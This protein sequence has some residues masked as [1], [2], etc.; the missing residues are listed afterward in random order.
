MLEEVK[1]IEIDQQQLN[2][3]HIYA[4]DASFFEIFDYP[5]L[6]GNEVGLFQKLYEAVI[7]ETTAIKYFEKVDVIG[8]SFRIPTIDKSVQVAGVINDCPKNTHL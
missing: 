8:K 1:T 4:A 3:T 2:E 6:H 5:L 7:T